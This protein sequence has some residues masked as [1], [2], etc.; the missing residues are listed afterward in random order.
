MKGGHGIKRH[1]LVL[2]SDHGLYF[3]IV[4]GDPSVWVVGPKDEIEAGVEVVVAQAEA[5][6]RAV[7]DRVLKVAWPHG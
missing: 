3:V 4:N 6:D 7:F 5:V 2:I 1:R